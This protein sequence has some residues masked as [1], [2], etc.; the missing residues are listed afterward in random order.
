MPSVYSLQLTFVKQLISHAPC[1]EYHFP[2]AVHFTET[3]FLQQ[4]Q[5]PDQS[6]ERIM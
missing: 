4:N 3:L 1:S 6:L 2:I 5:A